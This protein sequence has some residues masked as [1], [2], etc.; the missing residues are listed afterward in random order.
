[1]ADEKRNKVDAE[2]S[3][4]T[5]GW[6]VTFSDLATLLLTFF[7]LLLSM[8]AMDE[9]TFRNNFSNFTSACGILLFKEYEEI[10]KP[11]ENLMKG[12]NEQLKD[13]LVIRRKDDPTE[14][15][16]SQKDEDVKKKIG[17]LLILEDFE[18][19]FKLIF[20]QKLL[21]TQGSAKINDAI[22]PVL[23]K[24]ARFIRSTSYQIYIDGHTDNIPTRSGGYKDNSE[25]SITRAFNVMHFLLKEARIPAGAMAIAGYGEHHPLVKNDTVPGRAQNRRV[26][27]IFM[28]RQF[29]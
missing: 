2:E 1:M 18:D 4:G 20:G 29:L 8:S 24:L 16:L 7:V 9:R 22:K 6:M 10:Y 12:I 23:L 21:F 17:N 25:L 5:P 15:I 28:N 14:E 13:Q 27:I 11:K 19:G 3:A 26:E